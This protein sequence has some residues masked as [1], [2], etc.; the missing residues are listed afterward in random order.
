MTARKPPCLPL[1]LGEVPQF[2]NWG[3]EGKTPSQSA[4]CATHADSSPRG[5][6][7]CLSSEGA[8]SL[9]RPYFPYI[10][11]MQKMTASVIKVTSKNLLT[12]FVLLYHTNPKRKGRVSHD[13][14]RFSKKST[15]RH[16][17]QKLLTNQQKMLY[18]YSILI[19][20]RKGRCGAQQ[21][22]KYRIPYYAKDN[23]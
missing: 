22:M 7:K 20:F 6:A 9:S 23:C 17:N 13:S 4:A 8:F 14:G 3:R 2:A 16:G 10:K 15:N 19:L 18:L 5:R 21:G 11:P 1:P 12:L